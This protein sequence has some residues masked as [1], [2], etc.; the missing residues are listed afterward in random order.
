MT[1]LYKMKV[2]IYTFGMATSFVTTLLEF[3]KI[4]SLFLFAMLGCVGSDAHF[5]IELAF[6]F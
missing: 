6:F 2:Y 1:V 5:E 4:N 3:S